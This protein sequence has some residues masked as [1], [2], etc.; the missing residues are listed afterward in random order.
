[1]SAHETCPYRGIPGPQ[2]WDRAFITG[3]P[4]T[5]GAADLIDPYA[6]QAA[7]F[8]FDRQTRIVTAGSCF[9]QNIARRLRQLNYNFVMTEYDAA[10]SPEANDAQRNTMFSARYGNIYTVAHLYQLIERAYGRWTPQEAHWQ[11][12]DRFFDPYRPS[13]DA[14]G[15]GS[16]EDLK[17]EREKHLDAVRAAL[18]NCDVFVFTLGLTEGWINRQDGAA[19]PV[20]PGCGFGTFDAEKYAFKNYT[21]DEINRD[22]R[23]AIAALRAVNPS[24]KVILT[25]SPVPL[26]ATM[27]ARHILLSTTYSKSVLRIACESVAREIADVDYFASFEIVNW[28]RQMSSYFTGDLR[29]VSESGVDHVMKIFFRYYAGEEI[30]IAPAAALDTS[31]TAIAS[32]KMWCDDDLLLE[33]GLSGSIK[34]Q[35][36]GKVR[37]PDEEDKRAGEFAAK[38]FEATAQRHP[39]PYTGWKG[40]PRSKVLFGRTLDDNGYYNSR[41][42]ADYMGPEYRRICVLGPSIVMDL[43]NEEPNTIC[44]LMQSEL[45]ARGHDKVFVYNCGI[46]ASVTGMDISNLL[47]YVTDFYPDLVVVLSSGVDFRSQLSGDPRVGYPQSYFLWE[48]ILNSFRLERSAKGLS[49]HLEDFEFNLDEVRRTVGAWSPEW[50]RQILEHYKRLIFKIRA[51][52]IGFDFGCCVVNPPSLASHRYRRD[53]QRILKPQTYHDDALGRSNFFRD[54][55]SLLHERDAFLSVDLSESMDDLEAKDVFTELVHMHPIGYQRVAK[56][57]VDEISRGFPQR[58]NLQVNARKP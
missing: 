27:E 43:E 1:M 16:L 49:A 37:D 8:R 29:T 46:H 30:T 21:L 45:T 20:C 53:G 51:L 13:V 39:H 41:N 38:K 50:C 28:G 42:I 56:R 24:V 31:A 5:P 22:L 58:L 7:G 32:K 18:E 55:L 54:Q 25:V 12:G 15:F 48:K 33:G 40:V 35:T 2:R 11:V 44:G 34:A 14:E 9:A 57:L 10:L 4:G 3:M 6:E 47:H 23:R 17:R 19:Y 52:G 36:A 26:A